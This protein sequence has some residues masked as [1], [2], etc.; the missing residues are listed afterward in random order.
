MRMTASLVFDEARPATEQTVAHEL[1]LAQTLGE[2]RQHLEQRQQCAMAQ[3]P[4]IARRL[5]QHLQRIDQPHG[6]APRTEYQP[7]HQASQRQAY[8]PQPC[9]ARLPN[10]V[11][12]RRRSM[13]IGAL[14]KGIAT[15]RSAPPP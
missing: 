3:R 7:K 13:Q 9:T 4:A 12:L 2:A 5:A 1:D 14:R 8:S 15:P 6:P 11:A 10:E